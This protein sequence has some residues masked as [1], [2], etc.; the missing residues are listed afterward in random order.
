MAT[1]SMWNRGSRFFHL[2]IA[3][4]GGTR[5]ILPQSTVAGSREGHG[6]T[7]TNCHLTWK[8]RRWIGVRLSDTKL[9]RIKEILFA[10][11]VNTA[12]AMR[13]QDIGVLLEV[14]DVIHCS[15][16]DDRSG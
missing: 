4:D 1:L 11:N 10:Q 15:D 2:E 5:I 8:L 9:Q 7:H 14:A 13:F 6:G 12:N 3:I 16:V